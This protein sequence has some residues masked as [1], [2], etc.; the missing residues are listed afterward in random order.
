[1][2]QS[3]GVLLK[4][5]AAFCRCPSTAVSLCTALVQQK[6]HQMTLCHLVLF[7]L[8]F[9][10]SLSAQVATLNRVVLLLVFG[11]FV[12]QNGFFTLGAHSVDPGA[13][14]FMQQP[15]MD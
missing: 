2:G 3:S 14:A 15:V 4:E 1:M 12:L 10:H 13:S 7:H 5:V 6:G 9:L 11:H 8:P